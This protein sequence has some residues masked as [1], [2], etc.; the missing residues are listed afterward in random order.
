MSD[1]EFIKAGQTIEIVQ[2][3]L[4]GALARGNTQ[5]VQE[6][7]DFLLEELG[8]KL[9]R[10]S[11]DYAKLSAAILKTHVRATDDLTLRQAGEV[12]ETPLAPA[13]FLARPS[14][15]NADNPPLSQVFEMYK[16]EKQQ[17]SPKTIMDFTPNIRRFIELHGD[18]A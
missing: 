18:W 6:E 8:I 3:G 16:A 14:T 4:K 12:V 7:V 10:Y 1:R 5:I 11:Q 2:D 13:G 15:S 9:D 17:L